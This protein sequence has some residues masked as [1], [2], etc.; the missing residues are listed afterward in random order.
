MTVPGQPRIFVVDDNV[1][2][3]MALRDLSADAGIEVIGEAGDSAE[4][5]RRI[6]AMAS[7]R[8]LIVLMDVRLPGPINGIEAT[9]VLIDRCVDVGVLIFTAFP[10][11]GIEQ[12]ARQAGAAALLAKGCPAEMIIEAV[13]R[14]WSGLVPVAR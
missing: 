10:G 12:A 6:P 5:I 9:R 8:P 13:T 1:G 4:A 11:S 7:N 3:R 2:L 14:A